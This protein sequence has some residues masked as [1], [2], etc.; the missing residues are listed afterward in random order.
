MAVAV[1]LLSHHWWAAPAGFIPGVLLP[2][3]YVWMRRR[4]RMYKL[5]LQ[6]PETFDLIGRAIRAGQTVPAAFHLVGEDLEPPVCE[7]FRRCYEQQNLGMS[8]EMAMR[9]L[10]RRTGIMEMRILAI[11]FLVQTRAGGNLHELLSNLANLVRTRIKLQQR[12]KA[13]T[14][15]ARLQANVLMVLPVA[16]FVA[17]LVLAPD[18]ADTLLREP[19]LLAGTLAAQAIGALWIQRII[20]FDF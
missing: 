7:E 15:E 9:G 10:A 13:L 12:V 19:R 14:G 5:L 11:A 16:A 17:L 2:P 4:K 6:L 18:Y 1:S 3:L 8:F 20:N